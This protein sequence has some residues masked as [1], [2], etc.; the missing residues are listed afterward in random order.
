MRRRARTTATGLLVFGMA[1]A[2]G[3]CSPSRV[4]SIG[5]DGGPGQPGGGGSGASDGPT[6]AVPDGP[7][8]G[9][10]APPPR[11]PTSGEQCV[12]EAIRGEQ[13]PLDLLLVLDASG[14][15]NLEVGGQTRW[16]RVTDALKSF[17]ADPRSAG[18]G[19]GLQVFPFTISEKPCRNDGDCGGDA[20]RTGFYCTRPF[21]CM[22][23]GVAPATARPCDPND[24]F[25]PM[26]TDCEP[27]GRCTGSGGR[28][29]NLGQACP[30]AG[31]NCGDAPL[32][33]KLP[34][35][36]C[37]VADYERPRLPLAV[38]PAALPGLSG[39]LDSIKPGGNT[40]I[41]P[42]VGGAARYLR[43][44]L[45]ANPGRRGAPVLAS[46]ASPNICAGAD[47]AGVVAAIE[48]ARA[49]TPSLPSYVIGAVTPGDMIRADAA[50]RFA[51]AGG[52][53]TPFILSNVAVDLGTRFLEALSTIRGSALPCE[54][55]IAMPST[56]T[57]DFGKVNVR[58][59][60]VGGVSDLSYVGSS[61]RCD[62]TKGGW[63][64]DVDPARGTPTTVRVCPAN[65]ARFKAETGGMVELRFGCRTRID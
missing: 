45:A 16:K 42:A 46:D 60:G 9:L 41:A 30:G 14:S 32:V 61:E 65:C 50:A 55:R 7:D 56:G 3:A 40:P 63:Y 22:G 1:L 31:G 11:P 54:F 35:D 17:M 33:C 18:L 39:G 36:S 27:S 52:T 29:V 51:Q 5:R 21:L 34:L 25:C 20:A 13:L 28:C 48:T 64:Y 8:G 23:P 12:E 57:I 26:G 38:L 43:Q 49:G 59:V 44:H 15:M 4:E 10:E 37:E 24:A 47:V 58:F 2:L 6:L 62:P 19:V 53:G